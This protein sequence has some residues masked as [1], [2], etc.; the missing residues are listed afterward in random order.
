[1]RKCV[2]LIGDAPA[3]RLLTGLPT[4]DAA[5]FKNAP[6]VSVLTTPDMA[7]K[8]LYHVSRD[9]EA[10]CVP[11]GNEHI[12][13]IWLRGNDI[14]LDATIGDRVYRGEV[15]RRAHFAL[16][17][18]GQPSVWEVRR[19]NFSLLH[20][21][22]SAGLVADLLEC[23]KTPLDGAAGILSPR[24]AEVEW[25][26]INLLDGLS[27][28]IYNDKMM[29]TTAALRCA[30]LMLSLQQRPLKSE[31]GYA[32]APTRLARVKA[33][34]EENL[35]GAIG[36]DDLAVVSGL[37]SFHFARQFRKATGVAPLRFVMA[38]RVERAK[39]LLVGNDFALSEVAM[40]AGFADQSHF[41]TV[42]KYF[43]G[44]PPG[45]WRDVV[46]E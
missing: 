2:D 27:E 35:S 34:I 25:L 32:L 13:L 18:A 31:K 10:S 23:T 19:G 40:A 33:F 44:L 28:G 46:K 7:L 41:S 37:S 26:G 5:E 3:S 42:F 6:K 16:I 14:R 38:R 12:L 22:L 1:M 30:S 9:G 15:V 8:A 17:P 4:Y 29:N 24:D 36:V 11:P 39:D 21:H 45:R 43:T 20:L